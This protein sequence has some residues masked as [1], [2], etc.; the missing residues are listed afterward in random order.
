MSYVNLLTASEPGGNT[1]E[2]PLPLALPSDREAIEVALYSSLC[3]PEPR[4]CRIHSTAALDEMWISPALLAEAAQ[5]PRI[6]VVCEP[7]PAAFDADGNL[8]TTED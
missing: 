1:R 4:V 6:D 2:G 5:N 7:A 8:L 3:G